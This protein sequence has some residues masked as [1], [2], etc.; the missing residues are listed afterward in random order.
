MRLKTD[1]IDLYQSHWDDINTAVDETLE[2]YQQL[3]SQGKVRSIGASNFSKER[4]AEAL[5][6]AD[7]MGLPRYETFQP[8]Y[9]LFDREEYERE[10]RDLCV[11]RQVGVIPYYGLASGFLS[12]KYRSEN[13][14]SKSPR[15]GGIQ[16]YLTPRGMR[17]LDAL[18]TVAAQHQVKPATIALAWLM[19]RPGITAPIASATSPGQL[20]DLTKAVSIRLDQESISLLERAS[21]YEMSPANQ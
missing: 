18:D 16:K 7:K 14:L 19:T 1:Y 4:L 3:I 6:A 12:G 5:D 10:Y 8:R 17:I 21:A 2:A 13:D 15:G 20:E 11:D 9:N